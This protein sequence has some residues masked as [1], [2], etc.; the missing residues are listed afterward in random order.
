M[1]DLLPTAIEAAR[2][3]GALLR[4]LQGGPRTI[5]HKGA[6]NLVTDG[7][8]RSEALLVSL[9]RSRFPSHSILSE[10]GRNHAGAA[11]VCWILDPLDGT[12]N[13]AHGFPFYSVSVA[14]TVRGELAVGVVYDPNR[15]ECFVTER[16]AGAR[17]NEAPIRVSATLDLTD[18]L[19]CTGFPY[20]IREAPDEVIRH[21]QAFLVRAQAVRRPG[22][23]ALDLAYVAAGRLDAFW[24]H[25]IRA[26]D[27]AAGALLVREAGGRVSDYAGSP[28][29]IHRGEIVASNGLLHEAMVEVLSRQG[30]GRP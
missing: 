13:F 23:A 28:L 17:M 8:R 4:N 25:K 19:L 30:P 27:L 10:E 15:D 16:G 2:E 9:I 29:D 20:D 24:E 3:A 18:A 5:D 22:S 12:T 6:I 21:F 14:V 1:G 7:D 11:D 26:W